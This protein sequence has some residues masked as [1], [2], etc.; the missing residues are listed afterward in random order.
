MILASLRHG[1]VLATLVASLQVAAEPR[2]WTFTGAQFDDGT[3]ITGSFSYD[4]ATRTSGSGR[5][6]L[7]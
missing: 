1:L 2:V 7:F 5:W 6:P 3:F 4:D